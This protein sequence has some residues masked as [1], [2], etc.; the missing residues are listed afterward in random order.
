[1]CLFVR[2]CLLLLSNLCIG[3]SKGWQIF[4]FAVRSSV[5]KGFKRQTQTN[6]LDQGYSSTSP[7]NQRTSSVAPLDCSQRPAAP[8]QVRFSSLLSPPRPPPSSLSSPPGSQVHRKNLPRVARQPTTASSPC[9]PC[10]WCL[11]DLY[12]RAKNDLRR[13]T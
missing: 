2:T 12:S 1:M 9:Q 11:G 8:P 6:N 13:L 4:Y 10:R 3:S 7:S 5:K